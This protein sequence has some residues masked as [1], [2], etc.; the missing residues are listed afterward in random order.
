MPV[1]VP[2]K[3]RVDALKLAHDGRATQLDPLAGPQ[4]AL[5]YFGNQSGLQQLQ[6]R[7]YS[8]NTTQ[9]RQ[10]GRANQGVFGQISGGSLELSNV[11]LTQEL[12]EMIVIQSGFQASSQVLTVANSMLQQLYNSTRPGG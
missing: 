4:L 7:L 5:A 2:V 8:G 6:G 10:I 3:V 11:N 1:G 9:Q 12:A